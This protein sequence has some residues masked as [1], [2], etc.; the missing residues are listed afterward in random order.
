MFTVFQ[1]FNWVGREKVAENFGFF[2]YT[3]HHIKMDFNKSCRNFNGF[4][5]F[6]PPVNIGASEG[7]VEY[8]DIPSVKPLTL[9]N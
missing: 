8:S 6:P 5:V 4:P 7:L 1:F 3:F 2:Y 9:S